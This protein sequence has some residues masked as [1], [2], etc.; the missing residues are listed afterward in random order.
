[1][2]TCLASLPRMEA[3]VAKAMQHEIALKLTNMLCRC[4]KH[5]VQ[6]MKIAES[7]SQQP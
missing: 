5:Y 6:C 7:S 2:K 3:M 1:M 4:M